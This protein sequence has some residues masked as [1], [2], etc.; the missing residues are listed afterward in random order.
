MKTLQQWFVLLPLVAIVLAAIQAVRN[1]DALVAMRR[2]LLA[3]GPLAFGDVWLLHVLGA[4]GGL[5]G[6]W[7]WL[8]TEAGAWGLLFGAVA[9]CVSLMVE[10]SRRGHLRWLEGKHVTVRAQGLLLIAMALEIERQGSPLRILQAVVAIIGV[11]FLL[12]PKMGKAMMVGHRSVEREVR[13][14][15]LAG[16]LVL[17]ALAVIGVSWAVSSLLR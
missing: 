6:I 4:I 9:L 7:L 16:Y 1:A 3:D 11:G 17:I 15:R 8:D 10:L 2:S 5:M 14:T 12:F 13:D